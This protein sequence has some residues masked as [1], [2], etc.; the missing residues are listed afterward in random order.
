MDRRK[1]IKNTLI[2]AAGAVIIGS[3]AGCAGIDSSKGDKKRKYLLL[4]EAREQT[5]TQMH[6]RIIL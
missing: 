4:R 1:F 3:A 2:A 6:W 5:E